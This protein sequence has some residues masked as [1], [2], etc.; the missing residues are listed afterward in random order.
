MNA[1][2]EQTRLVSRVV[3]NSAVLAVSKVL[4]RATGFVMAVLV[5]AHLGVDGLGVYS[6]VWAIY[7]LMALAGESGATNYLVREISRDR[8]RTA[9]YTTH[10]SMV[11]AGLAVTLTVAAELLV[12][13]LGYSGEMRA[14]IAVILLAILPKVLNMIQEGVFVAHGRVAFETLTRLVAALSYIGLSAWMLAHDH[15]VVDLLRAFVAIEA[16]VCV[17]YF[18]LINRFIARL[19]PRFH[20]RLALRLVKEVRYF[21]ASSAIAAV[22]ARPEVVIISLLSTP[23]EVGFYSAGM[24]IAEI[25]LLLP[26]VFMVNVFPVLSGAYRSAE[27]RFARWQ[28]TAVRVMLGYSLPLAAF[29]LVAADDLVRLLFGDGF[30]TSAAVVRLMSGNL[31]AYSLGA[32]FWRSL[33]ARGGQRQNVLIQSS[34]AAVRIATG[35]VLITAFAAVGAGIAA[36]ATAALNVWLLARATA[37]AGAPQSVLCLAWRF[38]PPAVLSAGIVWLLLAHV[39]VLLALA[40]GAIAYLLA[41]V[42]LGA[43]TADDRRV[44]RAARA[45]RRP[46]GHAMTDLH[47]A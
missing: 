17:T 38:V 27:D 6:A 22:F 44:L 42:A 23:S 28:A 25:G 36:A 3:R 35:V 8:S 41:A 45:R 2:S 47:E 7:A 24:R 34:M 29:L 16:V 15:G 18:V 37:R 30:G 21:A 14:G 4:E 5:T 11:A 13:H 31:V 10:L 19:R 9:S 32:V 46:V 43:I 39:P 33:V 20:P 40:A 26:D 1:G 12:P